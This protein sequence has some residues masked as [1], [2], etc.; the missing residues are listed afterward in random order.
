MFF[1]LQPD[2]E[3]QERKRRGKKDRRREAV[4]GLAGSDTKI[5]FVKD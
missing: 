4:L 5:D 3:R 2:V 1:I